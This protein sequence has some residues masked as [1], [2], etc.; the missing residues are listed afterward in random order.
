METSICV[1]YLRFLLRFYDNVA[2]GGSVSNRE[3]KL[4]IHKFE[5]NIFF[6]LICLSIYTILYYCII[7]SYKSF[8]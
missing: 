6:C 4:I 2:S 8:L 5:K 7:F 3:S 1:E